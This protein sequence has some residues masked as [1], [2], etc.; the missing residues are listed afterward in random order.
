MTRRRIACLLLFLTTVKALAQL[1]ELQGLNALQDVS[2]SD[3]SQQDDNPLAKV[4]LALHPDDWKHAEG[5][6]FIYHYVRSFVATRAAVEAEFNFRVVAKELEKEEPGSGHKS[7]IYFF[8]R[9]EDW[10]EFQKAGHLEPWTGGIQSAGSLFLLRD[11]AHKFSGHT[12]GHEIAHLIVYRLYGGNIPCWVNEGFAEYVSR[13]SRAS[14]QRARGYL[15]KPHSTS[16]APEELMPLDRLMELTY[17]PSEKVEDFYDECE[18]LVRFLARTDHARFL[19]FFALMSGKETFDNALTHVYAG[20]F[21]SRSDFNDKF[22]EYASKDYGTT[23]Q[24]QP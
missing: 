6:H 14:Y 2:L 9:P 21:A 15:A 18:R 4:A 11:P 13:N 16:L 3:L 22:R 17:P 1:N 20:V 5:E 7:H 8:D 24:D 19:T 12:L 23:L 10:Q